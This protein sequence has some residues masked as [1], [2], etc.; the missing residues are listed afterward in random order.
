VNRN[1]SRTLCR[2]GMA[3]FWATVF[4]AL[5]LNLLGLYR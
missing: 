2:I 3:G 4:V 1:D 5:F